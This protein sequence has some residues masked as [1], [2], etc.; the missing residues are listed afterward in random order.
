[1]NV[2]LATGLKTF[3]S[4]LIMYYAVNTFWRYHP[5]AKA[6]HVA[7]IVVVSALIMLWYVP[8]QPSRLFWFLGIGAS[9]E[10]LWYLWER[11]SGVVLHVLFLSD[12]KH[13]SAIEA[14]L[15]EAAKRHRMEATSFRFVFGS[16]SLLSVGVPVAS[17]K[18]LLKELERD[19][20]TLVPILAWRA[21]VTVLLALIL[22]AAYW[23]YW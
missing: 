1:M 6:R 14:Y 17:W 7:A 22:L 18:L 21:Y 11:K 9:I 12:K 8:D 19:F 20:R 10:A 5:I 23:R 15:A 3:V 2:W 16:A 13:K 4:V